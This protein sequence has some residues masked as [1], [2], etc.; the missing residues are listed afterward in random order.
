MNIK[1]L[2]KDI[3][4]LEDGIQFM[5]ALILF[6]ACIGIPYSIYDYYTSHTRMH[7]YAQTQLNQDVPSGT[8]IT[9]NLPSANE[10]EL[11]M[12]IDHG[13]IITSIIRNGNDK[14]VYITC[15]KR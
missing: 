6:I 14:T 2:Y 5:L 3:S 12:I 15:E 10:K 1:G 4:Q 8:I 11:N 13:Y 9:I 7:E